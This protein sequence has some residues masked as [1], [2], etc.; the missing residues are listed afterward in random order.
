M[1][2]IAATP[3]FSPAKFWSVRLLSVVAAFAVLFAFQLLVI[4]KLNGYD[5][6][7]LTL[8]LFMATLA[9]S[10]NII[11]GITGQFSMGHAAFYVVG[12]YAGGK[13]TSSYFAGAG[14]NGMLWL[15]LMVLFGAAVAGVAGLIVGLPSLRLKGDYLA[16][17]TLGFGEIVRIFINNQDGGKEAIFGLDLGGS[18]QLMVGQKLT[19]FWHVGLLLILTI[20][21]S[22]NLLKSIHG[23]SFLAT[24]EDELAASAVG[25]NTTKTRV[26]AFVMGAGL[27]GAAGVLF[28]HFNNTVSPDDGSMAQSFLIVAMVVIGGMGS[29]TGA[30]I[31]GFTLSIIPE[32][33][34]RF[35]PISAIDLMGLVLGTIVAVLLANQLKNRAFVQSKIWQGLMTAFGLI[36]CG[37]LVYAVYKNLQTGVSPVIKGIFFL[38]SLITIVALTLTPGRSALPKFGWFLVLVGIVAAI[39]VPISA[40]LHKIPTIEQNLSTTTYTPSDLRWALFAVAL[41]VVMIVRPQGILGHHEWSWSALGRMFGFSRPKTEVS[42]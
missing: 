16:I 1:A 5:V 30:A 33:L 29:I 12:A 32:A 11:N 9:V 4:P 37:L 3:T 2:A 42:A 14:M 39:K 10:L 41:V 21:I 25:V 13:L 19:Q 7:I 24:R 20:A 38:L 26:A 6:R 35:P 18:Y 17:V 36:F 23:L 34:R 28:A 31:A 27:A 22:R 8:G 40:M 15:L